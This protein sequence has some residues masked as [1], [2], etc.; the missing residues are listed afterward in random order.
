MRQGGPGTSVAVPIGRETH[1]MTDDDETPASERRPAAPLPGDPERLA[2]L[3]EAADALGLHQRTVRR[4][5]DY[6]LL[7]GYKVGL[8]AVRVRVADVNRL[9]TNMPAIDY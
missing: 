2:T 7:P 3:A 1:G 5:I 6:G 9:V 4:W 8:R